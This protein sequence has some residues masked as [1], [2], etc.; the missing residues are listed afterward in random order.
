MRRSKQVLASLGFM[1]L[2]ATGCGGSGDQIQPKSTPLE[3]TPDVSESLSCAAVSG[4][5]YQSQA[6]E[7]IIG[8]TDSL[9][10]VKPHQIEPGRIDVS[11]PAPNEDPVVFQLINDETVNDCWPENTAYL[12]AHSLIGGQWMMDQLS[13]PQTGAR[14]G[15]RMLVQ[16][17]SQGETSVVQLRVQSVGVVSKEL[18]S[19]TAEIWRTESGR[20]VL[21][22]SY[23][24]C[25]SR[26][27]VPSPA[28]LTK[29]P[30]L[31][32]S[33]VSDGCQQFGSRAIEELS[34]VIEGYPAAL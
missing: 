15:D 13:V 28:D 3:V 26:D 18:M 32:L 23:D 22:T 7:W 29:L 10:D 30:L 20:V 14:V 31:E 27:D 34:L 12:S 19:D 9:V 6:G 8:Q 4:L 21:M 24:P 5:S 25:G 11:V 17:T 2:L 33:D 1:T 16:L